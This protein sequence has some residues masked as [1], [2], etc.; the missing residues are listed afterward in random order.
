MP[1]QIRNSANSKMEYFAA[2][3][4][5][6]ILDPYIS[7]YSSQILDQFGN[8][9]T[10]S[11]GHSIVV[12][13]IDHYLVHRGVSYIYSGFTTV[14]ANGVKE[15]LLV[16]TTDSEVHLKYFKLTS[17][18]AD[19]KFEMFHAV[20]TTANGSAL[21]LHN[22]NFTSPN[23]SQSALTVDPTVTAANHLVQ[24]FLLLGGKHEGGS[25]TTGAA[26]YILAQNEDILFRYTNASNSQV[27]DL[28]LTVETL[29]VGQI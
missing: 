17:K 25:E 20:T 24:G 23:L 9:V 13:E 7:T 11:I 2:T 12:T 1:Y 3:G 10:D 5:G 21:V 18:L 19:G 14:A 28:E 16:N 8:P 26:E 29:G 6:T 4:D 15:W 27:D 22:K